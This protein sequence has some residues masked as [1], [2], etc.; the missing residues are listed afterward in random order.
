M[1]RGGCSPAAARTIG[2]QST[3]A[4][5]VYADFARGRAL[6]EPTIDLGPGNARRMA[7]HRRS[8]RWWDLK[9]HIQV[10]EFAHD[11]AAAPQQ[12]CSGAFCVTF[13]MATIDSL[14]PPQVT[15][16]AGEVVSWSM[17]VSM[18]SVLR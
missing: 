7:A 2:T 18:R 9:A 13:D 16:A 3:G 4:P 1:T 17:A 5:A 11:A 8:S 10:E 14:A 15:T 6:P 12:T